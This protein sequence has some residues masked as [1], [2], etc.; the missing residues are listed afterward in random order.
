MTTEQSPVLDGMI[1]ELDVPITMDDGIVL[2]A[3]TKRGR[4]PTRRSGCPRTTSASGSTR[5]ARDSPGV[6]ESFSPREVKDAYDC[7]EWAGVQPWSSGK[8]AM[9]GISY[10]AVMQWRVAALQPPHLA[11]IVVWE[12]MYDLYREAAYHGGIRSTFVDGWYP[13]QVSTVQHGLGDRARNGRLKGR[14]VAGDETFTDERRAANKVDFDQE[15]VRHPHDDD[16]FADRRADL[17]K[18]TVP[19]LSAANWEGHGLHLRGNL[20]AYLGAASENKWLELHGLEHWV[21]YYTDYGRELQFLDH[22]L[23]GE[24]NGW[25]ERPPVARSGPSCTSTPRT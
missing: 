7:V 3:S 13:N 2:R 15:L 1:V 4:S 25:D 17:S 5:E 16:F 9:S 24:N 6:I 8:V 10:Y 20:E 14:S 19:L 18:V 22:F 21:H 12:G 23:K 11:A